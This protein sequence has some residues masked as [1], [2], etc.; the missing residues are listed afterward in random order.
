MNS[1]IL[2]LAMA[3]FGVAAQKDPCTLLTPA[4]IQALAPTAKIGAGAPQLVSK[5]LDSHS[6]EYTWGTG[7]NIQSGKS[8]FHIEV[9]DASKMYSGTSP[10]LIKQGMLGMA[11]RGGPNTSQ[12]AGVGDAAI[13]ESGDTNR[14]HATAYAKGSILIIAFES[15][16]ARAKKDQVIALLKAATARL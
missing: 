12:I 9:G 11:T 16:N 3:G 5:E 15:T 1:L 14:A 13:F 7:N 4:E 2:A 8:Y 6:C 10:A